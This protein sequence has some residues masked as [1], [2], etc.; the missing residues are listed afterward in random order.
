MVPLDTPWNKSSCLSL[1]LNCSHFQEVSNTTA[2]NVKR[3]QILSSPARLSWLAQCE[4]CEAEL[5]LLAHWYRYS[6][7]A[8]GRLAENALRVSND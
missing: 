1:R 7:C 3:R 6:P 4:F 8:I 2:S 5:Q